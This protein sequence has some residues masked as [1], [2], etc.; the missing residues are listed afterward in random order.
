MGVGW[1]GEQRKNKQ[2]ALETDL[3]QAKKRKAELSAKLTELKAGRKES[4]RRD[5][6][7]KVRR[8]PR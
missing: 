8:G 7:L 4:D 1:R 2:E 6:L 5:V 3:A